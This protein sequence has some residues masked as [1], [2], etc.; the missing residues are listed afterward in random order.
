MAKEGVGAE[1]YY[2]ISLHEQEC[3]A[4]LGYRKGD[5]PESEKAEAE[6]LALPIFPE[7]R[8]DERERVVAA[9]ARFYR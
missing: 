9:I 7:L 6:V 3:F 2:P 4:D 1:I 5:F 8:A